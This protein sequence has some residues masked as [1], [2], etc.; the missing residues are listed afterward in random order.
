MKTIIWDVDDVLN[1]LMRIWFETYWL[2]DHPKCQLNYNQISEN[3][4]YRL[5][6]IGLKEYLISLDSFRHLHAASLNPLP[7]VLTWF[8]RYG[9]LF[10]HAAL[11]AAPLFAAEISAGW[12]M[13]HFGL[14][15]RSFNFVPSRRE[16]KNLPLYNRNKGEFLRWWAKSAI[17]VD[18]S[19]ENTDAAAQQGF[20][21][22]LMP[23]PWN[24]SNLT[25]RETLEFL[26]SNA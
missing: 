7:A 13:K 26:A 20:D 18:D 2:P 15:I 5:L 22:I 11:T 3:P 9:D 10:R 21:A 14:W 8:G 23:R 1:D 19:L 16:G 25:E 4:P 24:K 17:L 12:V 6:G